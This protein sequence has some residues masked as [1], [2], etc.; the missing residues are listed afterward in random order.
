MPAPP[1]ECW[2]TNCN[3]TIRAAATVKKHSEQEIA[4]NA[5]GA[6][7]GAIAASQYHQAYADQSRQNQAASRPAVRMEKSLSGGDFTMSGEES[8]ASSSD[9]SGRGEAKRRRLA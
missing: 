5:A 6:S 9:L 3:G 7:R 1:K 2:C 4:R 8:E